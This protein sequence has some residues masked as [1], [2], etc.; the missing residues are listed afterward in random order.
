MYDRHLYMAN[1]GQIYYGIYPGS[2]Q[3]IST[4]ASYADGNWH[5]A[6]AVTS[7]TDGSFLYIDGALVTSDASM[8]TSQSYG[9]NGYWRIAYDNLDGWTNQPSSRYFNGS[10][11]DIAIYKSALTASQVYSLYGAGSSPTCAGNTLS[12]QANSVSGATYS[13]SGPNGFTSTSQNPTVTTNAATANAGTYTLTVTSSAGCTTT[14]TVTAVVNDAPSAAFTATSTV[15]IGSNATVTYSG[16][17]ASASTYTW[18]FNG[19]TIVSGSGVGPYTIN[20]S[21]AGTKTIT[22]TALKNQLH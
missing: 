2:V 14:T 3:T 18:D 5:H 17:Y 9:V 11:D 7:T 22:L 10:L 19:G 8:T 12:L 21:S 20:W 1:G 4:S 16:T 13:W 15:Q 6:V